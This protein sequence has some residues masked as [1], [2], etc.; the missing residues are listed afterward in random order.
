MRFSEQQIVE[1]AR[2]FD[3]IITS[4]S[5]AVQSAFQ[6]LTLLSALASD[7]HREPGPFE[8]LVRQMDWVEGELRSMQ[9]TIQILQNSILQNSSRS[10]LTKDY[11]VDPV[12]IINLGMH[13]TMAVTSFDLTTLQPLTAADIAN[14]TIPSDLA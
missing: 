8:H 13:N 14:I 6:R 10:E 5:A 3:D 9:R 1:F 2:I 7:D 12:Q 4:D 11:S